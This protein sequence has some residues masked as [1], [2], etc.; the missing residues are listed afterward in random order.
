VATH[1]EE[2]SILALFS[3]QASSIKLRRNRFGY[4]LSLSAFVRFANVL[5][6]ISCEQ[7]GHLLY[8]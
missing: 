1:P 4:A 5:A 6:A 2:S 3:H 8:I 7:L